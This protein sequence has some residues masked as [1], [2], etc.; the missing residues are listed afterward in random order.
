MADECDLS[1]AADFVPGIHAPENTDIPALWFLFSGD[2]LLIRS[3]GSGAEIPCAGTPDF[4]GIL[5]AGK[6]FLGMMK[7][8]PCYAAE[9]SGEAELPDGTSWAG[10]RGLHGSLPEPLLNIAGLGLQL[11]RWDQTHRYC[12]RCGA[13]TRDHSEERA[14][15]CP[16]CGFVNY[17]RISPAVIV[18]VVRE[19]R[20]LLARSSH[21]PDPRM[22][23]VIA[24]YVEPGETLEQTVLRELDEEVGICA[25]NLRYFRSQPWPYSGSLMVAFTAEYAS[26][27]IR[28]D[29]QEILE[30]GWFAP[31]RMPLLPG[32]GSVAG[33]LIRHFMKTYSTK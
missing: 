3:N 28:V 12:S 14:K 27:E 5:S 29:G 20:I 6:Q 30:A 4:P 18:S 23:S 25:K 13:K 24:G 21:Y 17:P 33:W 10:L 9:L 15:L 11:V 16:E 7:G 8:Q 22:Y 2:R 32:A 26:G 19:G 31:D 1:R